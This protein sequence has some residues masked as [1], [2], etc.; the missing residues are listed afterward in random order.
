MGL[1]R[2]LEDIGNAIIIW[3][4]NYNHNHGRGWPEY[5]DRD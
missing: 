2:I 4:Y 5:W 1:D 3:F